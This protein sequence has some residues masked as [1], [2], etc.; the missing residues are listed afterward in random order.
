VNGDGLADARYPSL[1]G[2]AYVV[3]GP[4]VPPDTDGD[5]VPDLEDNCPLVPN[6]ANEDRDGDALG[7]L[8]DN[9]PDHGNPEQTD[10]DAD[11]V[12]DACDRVGP[13]RRGDA[14]GSGDVPGT[15]ADM[16]RYANVCFLGTGA[17]PCRAAADFDGDG[18]VCGAVTDIVF[19]ANFLFL[20]SGPAPPEPGPAACA[21][22][23]LPEDFAL[24]CEDASGC[25]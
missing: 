4:S 11:G 13:F 23:S 7:D 2:A 25:S 12:G 14:D 22:S 6:S 5:G 17:F 16:I 24:G 3:F 15:T 10:T 18:Q 8:C 21:P 9:C 1:S 19:L 20:G